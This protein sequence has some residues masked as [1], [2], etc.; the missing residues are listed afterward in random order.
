[1]QRGNTRILRKE[2]PM[3]DINRISRVDFLP[4]HTR[5]AYLPIRKK[6]G[7]VKPPGIDIDEDEFHLQSEPVTSG[8]E[9]GEAHIDLD[10]EA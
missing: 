9:S 8:E 5:T 4:E 3:D 7:R 1:M 6:A 2:F 10:I